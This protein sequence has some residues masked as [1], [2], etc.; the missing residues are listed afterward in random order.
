MRAISINVRDGSAVRQEFIYLLIFVIASISLFVKFYVDKHL[1]LDGVGYFVHILEQ[2][3]FAEVAWS[4][5]FTEY[6][7]EWPLVL[8]VRL[9]VTDISA[10][11]KV[12][13]IGIYFP[14]L[15]SFILCWWAVRD[16]N[17]SLLWFPLAGYIAFNILSDYDLIADHH[18]MA[19]MT[20]PILVILLKSRALSWREGI[21]LWV[22]IIIYSRTYETAALTAAMLFPLAVVR[23]FRFRSQQEKI[24][25]GISLIL[26]IAVVAVAVVYIIY[27]RSFM[28]RGNFL[29]SIW[30]NRRNWEAVATCASLGIFSLAWLISGR[31]IRVKNCLFILALIPILYYMFLRFTSDY[32]MTA[33]ISFSSRTLSGIVL[34][35]LIVLAAIVVYTRRKISHTGLAVFLV[36]FL[37][38]ICFNLADLRNWIGV[39]QEFLKIVDSDKRYIFID[40]TPLSDSH[41]RWSWNNSL[42]SLVWSGTCV[43]T[44]VLNTPDDPQGPID[45]RKR[46]ILTRYL[47][48]D[49]YFTTVDPTISVCDK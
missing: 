36:I 45:P 43:S 21:V 12:F 23:L 30:V 32:A 46:L 2:Q 13:A 40:E 20:W 19:V 28:N 44:I 24:I 16:D 18:V 26:L 3:D 8:A 7:S 27:P 37:T 15:L 25:I 39:K 10:L 47:S 22:V 48:F 33:Y 42:L 35:G 14:Y 49:R 41:Y 31:W 29:D 9:G 1:A 5:R 4:R 17:K 6:L 34:P 11:I 38:M